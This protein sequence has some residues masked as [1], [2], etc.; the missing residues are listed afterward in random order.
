VI[1]ILWS[2]LFALLPS[3]PTEDSNN[4]GW[5]GGSN[6]KGAVYVVVDDQVWE[7]P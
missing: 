4:C 2:I 7:R 3:C 5:D 1:S 6:G